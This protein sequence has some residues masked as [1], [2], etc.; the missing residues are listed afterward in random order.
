MTPEELDALVEQKL[1]TTPT[2]APLPPPPPATPTP[3]PRAVAAMPSGMTMQDFFSTLNEYEKLRQ[4]ILNTELGKMQSIENIVA[5]RVETALATAGDGK[6]SDPHDAMMMDGLKMLV[7]A[8]MAGQGAAPKP[9]AP[10][11]PETAQISTK[12]PEP[13]QTPAPEENAQPAPSNEVEPVSKYTAEQITA[14]ANGIYEHYPKE[15]RAFKLGIIS[16]EQALTKIKLSGLISSE[17]AERV[18][19]EMEETEYPM[20]DE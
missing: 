1:P 9:P 10:K 16:R 7:Q 17:D 11:P 20:E 6:E 15:V 8:V 2:A 18:V 5:K 12:A 13:A 3:S 14:I 4:G 19:K